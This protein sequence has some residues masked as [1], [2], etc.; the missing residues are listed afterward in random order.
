MTGLTA[1]PKR[2]LRLIAEM[3]PDLDVEA[4][5]NGPLTVAVAGESWHQAPARAPLSLPAR[6]SG[7]AGPSVV[8]A[9]QPS[10]EAGRGCLALAEEGG[11]GEDPRSGRSR[12]GLLDRAD[13]LPAAAC[14]DTRRG[15]MTPSSAFA[16]QTSADPVMLVCTSGTLF[17]DA[18]DGLAQDLHSC[19]DDAAQTKRRLIVDMSGVVL[20]STAARR[21]LRLATDHLAHTPLLIVGATPVV[22][23]SLEH[24]GLPGI[25]VYEHLADALAA[26]SDPPVPTSRHTP[27][28]APALVPDGEQATARRRSGE[29]GRSGSARP[30][31]DAEFTNGLFSA[32]YLLAAA[33]PVTSVHA[34][35]PARANRAGAGAGR[36]RPTGRSGSRRGGCPEGR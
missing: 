5:L 15:L 3:Y 27:A 2:L 33:S 4:V 26:L 1:Q 28:P 12:S 10:E 22:R 23:R 16:F 7:H 8:G 6:E 20:L 35:A 21:T 18:C 30:G 32:F 25:R 11:E 14:T 34:A 29:A 9:R 36:V 24:A 31:V 13:G 17:A 19:L